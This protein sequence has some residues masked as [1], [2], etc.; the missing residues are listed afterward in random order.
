MSGTWWPR[1]ITR[2]YIGPAPAEE[3][4]PTSLTC[5][6]PYLVGAPGFRTW[7]KETIGVFILSSFDIEGEERITYDLYDLGE[8]LE[9]E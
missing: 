1:C 3:A 7:G 2:Q 4:L 8:S 6:K 5:Y 9:M